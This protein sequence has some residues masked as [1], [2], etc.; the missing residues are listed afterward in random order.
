M[1]LGVM[2]VFTGGLLLLLPLRNAW[3][4]ILSMIVGIEL[5]PALLIK[6]SDSTDLIDL[7]AYLL[8]I[9][10]AIPIAAKIRKLLPE[11]WRQLYKT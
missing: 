9:A 10:L 3:P 1:H 5:L 2:G 11:K 8:A 7:L 6:N 4:F